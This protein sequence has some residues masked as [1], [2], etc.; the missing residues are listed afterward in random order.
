MIFPRLF[1]GKRRT[2][3]PWENY[4][5]IIFLIIS[6]Q[7]PVWKWFLESPARSPTSINFV[8][9]MDSTLLT[10]GCRGDSCRCV[11]MRSERRWCMPHHTSA[12]HLAAHLL[13]LFLHS[14]VYI[15]HLRQLTRRG[16]RMT[17]AEKDPW[18]EAM[19]HNEQGR[20]DHSDI[21]L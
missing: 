14:A 1:C 2:K 19:E 9:W 12:D 10:V 20:E 11:C 18:K 3:D 21:T 6:K 13:G 5:L 17:H 15:F 16:V 7:G 4:F 8:K